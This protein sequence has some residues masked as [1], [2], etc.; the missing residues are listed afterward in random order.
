MVRKTEDQRQRTSDTN[1][2]RLGKR[3]GFGHRLVLRRDQRIV[4]DQIGI[5]GVPRPR[6]NETRGEQRRT[7]YQFH[8]LLPMECGAL[9]RRS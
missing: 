6:R 2:K 1:R 4:D 8:V 7:R 9:A 5:L 3:F